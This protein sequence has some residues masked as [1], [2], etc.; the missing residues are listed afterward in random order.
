MNKTVYYFDK[1]GD[2]IT[3]LSEKK[4]LDL[5][6]NDMI[7]FNKCLHYQTEI[8]NKIIMINNCTSIDKIELDK[9][10]KSIEN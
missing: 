6:F 4:F 2:K 9:L 7:V 5:Q 3:P 10:V 8:D 1:Y